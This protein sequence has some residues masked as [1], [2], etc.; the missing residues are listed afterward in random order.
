M[1]VFVKAH[2]RGRSV[3]RAYQRLGSAIKSVE[4]RVYRPN[5]TKISMDRQHQYY[6]LI[7]R[8][9][10]KREVAR[11]ALDAKLSLGNALLTGGKR[12]IRSSK[13]YFSSNLSKRFSRF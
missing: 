13:R 2:R 6:E 11:H 3:V 5:K 12:N 7:H 8:L 9:Q 4:N 1:P 10:T